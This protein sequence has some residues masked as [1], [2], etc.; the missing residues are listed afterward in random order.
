M[1]DPNDPNDLTFATE[2][3]WKFIPEHLELSP[4]A[5]DSIVNHLQEELDR[6]KIMILEINPERDTKIISNEIRDLLVYLGYN[7]CY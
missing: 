2:D 3:I 7:I 4:E 5:K 1:N 6:L